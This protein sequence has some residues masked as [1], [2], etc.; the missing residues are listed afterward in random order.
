MSRDLRASRFRHDVRA[1]G[2]VLYRATDKHQAGGDAQK[3]SA[4]HAGRPLVELENKPIQFRR[5]ADEHL[6]DNVDN[7]PVLGVDR[8]CATRAGS[9]E[10]IAVLGRKDE[11]HGDALFRRGYR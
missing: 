1:K 9:E 7:L 5:Y 4:I 8:A 3:N 2:R 11:A 6:A 10:K